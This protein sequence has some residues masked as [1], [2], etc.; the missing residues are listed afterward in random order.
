MI[1]HYN[2]FDELYRS[3]RGRLNAIEPTVCVSQGE[4]TM[5]YKLNDIITTP[6]TF[7][8]QQS[9]AN[10]RTKWGSMRLMPGKIYET[11]DKKLIESLSVR[12]YMKVPYNEKLEQTLKDHGKDY[13]VEVCK[14]CGGRV[15]K[16]KYHA[17]EILG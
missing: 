1:D 8:V 12:G 5:K 9:S 13:T 10:G 2:S 14:S 4:G 3:L 6:S 11:D 16:I 17:V 7:Y 15:K